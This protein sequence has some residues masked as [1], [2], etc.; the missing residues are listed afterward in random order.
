MNSATPHIGVG[1]NVCFRSKVF[2]APYTPYYD[3]YKGHHF[4]VVGVYHYDHI[5]LKCTT[6]PS[7]IV[8]GCVHSDELK[9]L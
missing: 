1:M 7:V 5:E 8:Q 9:R 6:D 4:E 2:E 3:A